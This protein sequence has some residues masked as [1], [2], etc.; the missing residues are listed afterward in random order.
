MMSNQTN[1]IWEGL[2]WERD[3]ILIGYSGWLIIFTLIIIRLKPKLLELK[4]SKC[5][6]LLECFE[7]LILKILKFLD[8]CCTLMVDDI[9]TIYPSITFKEEPKQTRT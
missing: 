2:Y 3:I 6:K 7:K 5:L 9:D 8:N 4:D 1:G